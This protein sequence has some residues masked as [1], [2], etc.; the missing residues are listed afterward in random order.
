MTAG[1]RL[2]EDR[3]L[4]EGMQMENQA[5]KNQSTNSRVPHAPAK[6]FC[7]TEEKKDKLKPCSYFQKA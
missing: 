7:W 2:L 5:I 4:V 1:R 3:V 6:A